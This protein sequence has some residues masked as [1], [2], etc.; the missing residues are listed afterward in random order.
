[1]S[2]GSH[3]APQLLSILAIRGKGANIIF[4]QCHFPGQ[5]G[6][7][8][9]EEGLSC[10]GWEHCQAQHPRSQVLS[11][12]LSSDGTFAQ[13]PQCPCLIAGSHKGV[14]THREL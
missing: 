14:T 2:L 13:F 5:A 3:W 12:P 4:T 9:T 8:G 7:L 11:S 1:M 6:H 10:Q